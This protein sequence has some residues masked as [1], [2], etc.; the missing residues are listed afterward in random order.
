MVD[1]L[2]DGYTRCTTHV[3]IQ[4]SNSKKA[5]F[6]AAPGAT[7]ITIKLKISQLKSW[8]AEV[9]SRG[10]EVTQEQTAAV[11]PMARESPTRCSRTIASLRHYD[12]YFYQDP[13]L[14]HEP[15]FGNSSGQCVLV[16]QF[17]L[18]SR[19]YTAH[20]PRADSQNQCEAQYCTTYR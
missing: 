8:P 9:R 15:Q 10:M 3:K 18:A 1:S 6:W 5:V 16:P 17:G 4:R 2:R 20:T 13:D 19:P 11:R 12:V 7:E 14:S